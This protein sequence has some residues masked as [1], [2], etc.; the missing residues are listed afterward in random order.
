MVT[1]KSWIDTRRFSAPNSHRNL[2][3]FASFRKMITFEQKM[4]SVFLAQNC[5]AFDPVR[6]LPQN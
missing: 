4:D 2:I 1:F 3:L 6:V 5:A